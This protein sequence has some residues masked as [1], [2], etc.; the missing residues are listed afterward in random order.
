MKLAMRNSLGQNYILKIGELKTS[1]LHRGIKKDGF[2]NMFSL[3]LADEIDRD[4]HLLL[5]EFVISKFQSL[6]TNPGHA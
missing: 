1:S 3:E 4:F 6:T 5:A 2:P